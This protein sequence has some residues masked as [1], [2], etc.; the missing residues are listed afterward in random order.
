LF[1]C[2]W[3]FYSCTK[4]APRRIL[5]KRIRV[6]EGNR[7]QSVCSSNEPYQDSFVRSLYFFFLQ[8]FRSWPQNDQGGVERCSEHSFKSSD[9]EML[10]I[11][12][13]RHV[14]DLHAR[15]C[16]LL[17]AGLPSFQLQPWAASNSTAPRKTFRRDS[18]IVCRRKYERGKTGK[19]DGRS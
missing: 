1:F 18:K 8:F 13:T 7:Q 5:P 9:Q 17:F 4:L 14:C 6:F 3:L 16:V 19:R 10:W 2:L 12:C 15:V 11:S